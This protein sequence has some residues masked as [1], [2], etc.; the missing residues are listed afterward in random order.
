[1]SKM[2]Q[3]SGPA[4]IIGLPED[5][6]QRATI[7]CR[8]VLV[9]HGVAADQLDELVQKLIHELGFALAADK[10]ELGAG[11]RGPRLHGSANVLSVVVADILGEYDIRG[12]WLL[13]GDEE[14]DGLMGPVAEIEAV[15]QS[16]L[17]EA[18]GGEGVAMARPARISNARK[19][20]GKVHRN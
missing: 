11:A 1:M 16:A 19:T 2:R 15:L 14:E 12:N 9:R 5:V 13:P 8:N 17:G 3:W 18:C 20:L 7:R 6:E 4:G 10:H